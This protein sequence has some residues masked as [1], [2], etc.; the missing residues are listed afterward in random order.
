MDEVTVPVTGTPS[1]QSSELLGHPPDARLLVVN[2]DDLGM[3]PAIN[4]AVIES[5]E[6]GIASSCSLMVPCPAAPQAMEL[7]SRRP[8][9]PFGIHL[10][11]VREMPDIPWGPLTAKERVASLLDPTGELFPPTPAGR[12]ALLGQARLGEVEL[13]FRAQIDAVADAGLAPTHLDF[14][15]LADGGRDDILDLTVM[16][17]AEYGLAVRVWLEPGRQTMRKRGLPVTDNDF[18]DSFS[19][20]IEGKAAR[21][22]QR[23][24]DLPAGLNEWAVHPSLGD[25]ESQTVDN[26]WPVRRTDYEFL[27][28]P[29]AREVLQQEEIVVIDYRTIQQVWSQSMSPR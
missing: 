26:G 13:E 24:R 15:C 11:L 5:V 19:L 4:A 20:D 29:Q 8:Q 27:T 25:E 16:L 14:H 10:T 1:G 17:A 18:L 22:A 21:Y 3:Y 7:L 23:L 12:A 28:S 6:E 9:I 2:C